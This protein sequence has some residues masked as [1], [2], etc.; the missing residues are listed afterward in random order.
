MD[1]RN[2]TQQSK[3]RLSACAPP[4]L[5]LQLDLQHLRHA[6]SQNK[7]SSVQPQMSVGR[8]VSRSRRRNPSR[9]KPSRSPLDLSQQRGMRRVL[10]VSAAH[11]QP[12]AR[13]PSEIPWEAPSETQLEAKLEVYSQMFADVIKQDALFGSV[14][15]PIKDF[16]ES[17]IKR[18]QT[19]LEAL[20]TAQTGAVCSHRTAAFKAAQNS[21]SS[22]ELTRCSP[23]ERPVLPASSKRE[24]FLISKPMQSEKVSA[25]LRSE[26]AGTNLL[27]RGM[28]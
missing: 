19:Q 15:V 7:L 5:A 6:H 22:A 12:K 18:L 17:Y 9:R 28:P 20:T 10:S 16:Y 8:A 4:D 27:A 23:Y 21:Q 14:L 24:G 1:K 11:T 13:A 2:P 25:L 26:I 3:K